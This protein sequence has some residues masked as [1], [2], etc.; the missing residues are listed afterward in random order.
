MGISWPCLQPLLAFHTLL[1]PLSYSL[2]AFV[3]SLYSFFQLACHCLDILIAKIIPP[4]N[5]PV[6]LGQEFKAVIE[7]GQ[8]SI[9]DRLQLPTAF[10]QHVGQITGNQ[11]S[12]PLLASHPL[13]GHIKGKPAGPR[14]ERP[15]GIIVS[16]FLPKHDGRL[17][18]DL[19][20]I[21]GIRNNRQHIPQN[22]S[23]CGEKK[24]EVFLLPLRQ[25]TI[26]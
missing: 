22:I 11:P 25:A 14:R 3:N 9:E 2:Q 20:R 10:Q 26:N 18:N 16:K 7:R 21:V 13:P 15:A 23:L 24:P 1:Q 4:D 6:P 8:P 19:L 5:L 17:L 12:P